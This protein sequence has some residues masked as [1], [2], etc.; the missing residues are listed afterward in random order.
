MATLSG[1]KRLVVKIGSALLVDQRT[2][3]LRQ[4]WLKTLAA[5]VAAL[6][7]AGKDVVLVSSGSIALGRGVLGLPLA[8]LP[9]EQSQAAAAVGQI[10]LARAYEEVLEPHGITTAQ[11]LVTLEDSADRR[12]YLNSR[13]TMETLLSSVYRLT[14]PQQ[15]LSK[16]VTH[17]Y[18]LRSL[19]CC[20]GYQKPR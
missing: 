18:L 19:V 6:K 1:A 17:S 16:F 11:I 10:Q 15:C 7:A 4:D 20:C 14:T 2:G 3:K 9:L 5:D 8:S 13:A 12:R